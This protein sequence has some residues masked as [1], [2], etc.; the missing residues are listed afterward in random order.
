MTHPHVSIP[1]LALFVLTGIAP[2]Q[3]LWKK[4]PA[5]TVSDWVSGPGGEKAAP[6]PPFK[7]QK[8]NL[9]GANAKIEVTDAAG[10]AWTVKFGSE[11]H[12]DT[13]AA[14]F[15]YALGY[16]ASPTYFV[17]T[18]VIDDVH[19]LKRA[20][21]FVRK[22]G[23][24]QKARF[25]LRQ[26]HKRQ[27]SWADNPFQGT[28]ELGGLKLVVMLLSNWDTK[29]SRDGESS[30]NGV[31]EESPSGSDG[32]FA[33]TDWGA[34]LGKSGDFFLRDRWNWRGYRDQ[35]QHFAMM[36]RD[37]SIKW[38]FHGKHK[39][40]IVKDVNIE[41]VRWLLPHLLRI[42]D[43][44]ITAGLEASGATGPVAR[45][46][47]RAIRE[48]VSGLQKISGSGNLPEISSK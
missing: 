18:G 7:F 48:R 37:G 14:R 24:F 1:A 29:D 30:N 38:G 3:V 32:W 12:S 15:L 43:E 46:F 23:S 35:T 21:Y 41:D 44:Q 22:D 40:D 39:N 25:K 28:R 9:G 11:V 27:W 34:S 5:L 45:E 26:A 4:P 47:T 20:K 17:P 31:F 13:F 10:K 36:R 8:E 33:V 2:A 19:D 6:R 16:A 42:T